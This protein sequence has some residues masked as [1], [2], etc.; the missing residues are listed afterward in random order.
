MKPTECTTILVGKKA[1]IDGSTMIARS[2]DGGR[3]IIPE[4]FKVVHPADHPRHYKSVITGCEVDL[5]EEPMRYT[6]VVD[7]AFFF[8][9]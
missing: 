3:E 2:E 4:S 1:S 5:P 8:Y 9:A 7:K 6:D